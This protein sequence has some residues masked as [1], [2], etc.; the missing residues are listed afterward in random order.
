MSR[1]YYSKPSVSDI[2]K[3]SNQIFNV[4]S[5]IQKSC[6]KLNTQISEIVASKKEEAQKIL[7]EVN[8]L[9][10]IQTKNE[11]LAKKI[12]AFVNS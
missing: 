1:L 11:G 10:Q 7:D 2:Q 6:A 8:E 4:F 12:D 5:T 3:R 9:T